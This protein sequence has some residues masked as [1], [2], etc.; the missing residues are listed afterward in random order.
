[1]AFD[2]DPSQYV[3]TVAAPAVDIQ[4]STNGHDADSAPGPS[5]EVG[6][7][8]N[9]T[10]LVT[11]VGNTTFDSTHTIVV[12]DDQGEAVFCLSIT[13]EPLEPLE[14]LD[15][16]AC[17]ATGTVQIGPYSNVGTVEVHTNVFVPVLVAS[18]TDASHY[19][20]VG[21]PGIRIEKSTNGEDADTPAEA[22]GIFAGTTVTWQYVVE[23]TGAVPLSNVVVTD[24]KLGA[25]CTIGTLGV[26]Q[27]P[28][29]CT[30]NGLAV[31]TSGLPG[32]VYAN[33]GTVTADALGGPGPDGRTSISDSDPSHY[34]NAA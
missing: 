13:F 33:V 17:T 27:P 19:T 6:T 29:S 15:S 20:G 30:A 26:G 9:W 31:L 21:S 22:V 32:G 5:L 2:S 11:N 4:K 18:D 1:M 8:V 10:Y 24:D 28:V 23:N 16:M 12:T 25:I 3:A 34:N 7:T 14:P